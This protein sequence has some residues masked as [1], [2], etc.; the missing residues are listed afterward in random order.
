M[1]IISCV[2]RV[3]TDELIDVL[4]LFG[5]N[6]AF[7]IYLDSLPWYQLSLLPDFGFSVIS[8]LPFSVSVEAHE[9]INI[10]SGHSAI[11]TYMH[12]CMFVHA[13]DISLL[14]RRHFLIVH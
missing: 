14:S 3:W 12:T 1:K 11:H 5:Y 13:R 4:L 7:V 8:P 9:P 10:G 6:L 2:Y